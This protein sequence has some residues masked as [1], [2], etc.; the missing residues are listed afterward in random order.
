MNAEKLLPQFDRAAVETPI[1]FFKTLF[2]LHE[3]GR[4]CV[5]PAIVEEYDSTSG[6]VKV[7]P[8][9]KS[10]SQDAEGKEILADR[11]LYS[12]HAVR[13]MHGGVIVES[14]LYKGDT[15]WLIASDRNCK[16]AMAENSA[17]LEGDQSY[18]EPQNKGASRPTDNSLA[19]FA[20]G[21]FIPDSWADNEPQEEG[22]GI[23]DRLKRFGIRITKGFAKLFGVG[24]SVT[25]GENGIDIDGTTLFNGDAIF[26][27]RTI[28]G[29][30]E[31]GVKKMTFGKGKEPVYFLATDDVE[32]GAVLSDKEP[33][34]VVTSSESASAGV[35]EEAARQDHVHKMPSNVVLTNV[36]QSIPSIKTI[37]PGTGLSFA[38]LAFKTPAE[39]QSGW[40]RFGVYQPNPFMRLF[41]QS[42]S[43]GNSDTRGNIIIGIGNV[44]HIGGQSSTL[45]GV[46]DVRLGLGANRVLGGTTPTQTGVGRLRVANV[47]WVTK[48]FTPGD[49]TLT[50]TVDGTS[51]T[52]TA[53]QTTDT[54]ITIPSGGGDVTVTG[55]DNVSQ[56]GNNLKIASE[57]NSNVTAR[58]TKSGDVV[59]ITLGVYYV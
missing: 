43:F 57:S 32:C 31:L 17:I 22:I 37:T 20:W 56:T 7:R 44:V 14:T 3:I 45:S 48:Y 11:P 39:P 29:D 51:Y 23:I 4:E 24:G 28:F 8:L 19:S 42:Q 25:V 2:R 38:N 16:D 9:A 30:T 52:F 41:L 5:I 49:G 26:K 18:D 12:V 47:G 33:L 36:N 21:F 55:T 40:V 50:I 35:A 53:N 6:I 34:D 27:G 58:V 15:G 54:S 46:D 10:V 13:S 59:T 1:G